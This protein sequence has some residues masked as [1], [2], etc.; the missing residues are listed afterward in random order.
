MNPLGPPTR[1]QTGAQ[2][3][4]GSSFAAA[5][6]L[7]EPARRRDLGTLYAFCRAADNVADEPGHDAGTRRAALAEWRAGFH[8]PDLRG[9]PD[10][11]AE[12]V[13]RR[14][15]DRAWGLA[16][17]D[18]VETDLAPAVRLATRDELDLYCHRVAGAVGRLCLPVFGADPGRAG[19]YAEAL[20]RALQRINI[21]RDAAEDLR[22]GRLYFP[23]DGLEAAGLDAETFARDERR[24][25]DYL[26]AFAEEAQSALAR[27]ASLQP[28]ED[29]AALRPARVMAAVYAALLAKMRRDGLR[30]ME[31]R[32]RL[33]AVEKALAAVRG[34]AGGQ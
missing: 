30:V 15:L 32:Y 26:E 33:T 3:A 31:Q 5:F 10:D 22:R 12:L 4:R 23:L 34:A 13:R 2:P 24:R 28:V 11:L 21:L 16:L 9:L 17:L 25:Q 29:R 20:G 18:G 1:L 6:L 27:A 7:L 14:G 19:D 8:D